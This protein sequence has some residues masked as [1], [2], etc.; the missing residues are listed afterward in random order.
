MNE[1]LTQ[2][3]TEK[4]VDTKPLRDKLRE[5]GFYKLTEAQRKNMIL[6]LKIKLKKP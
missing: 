2:L 1:L 4:N 6:S 5:Q 3:V